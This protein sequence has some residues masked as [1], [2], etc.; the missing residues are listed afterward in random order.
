MNPFIL[1]GAVLLIG[2]LAVYVISVRRE[3]AKLPP[4]EKPQ[5][6]EKIRR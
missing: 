4:L 3:I 2:V 6:P 5:Q 1:A